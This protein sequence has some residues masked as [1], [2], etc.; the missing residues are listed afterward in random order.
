MLC[1]TGLHPY[2][3]LVEWMAN[4]RKN[5]SILFTKEIYIHILYFLQRKI[6]H[7]KYWRHIKKVKVKGSRYRPCVAQTVGRG[8]ALLFHDRSTR[9]QWVV[10]GKS[11][12]HFTP[13]KD[14]VP[15]L[16]EAGWTPGPVW[17]S[18]KSRPY[19]DSIPDRPVRT[20]SLYRLSYPAHILETWAHKK[21]RG[22]QFP[23][24]SHAKLYI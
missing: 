6:S 23:I 22:W 17:T 21:T 18:E 7:T 1:T 8:I 4:Y 10:S 3:T 20:Q 12:P 14:L 16:Q 19:W 5:I 9:R 15:I 13:G 24:P 11:R 2:Y